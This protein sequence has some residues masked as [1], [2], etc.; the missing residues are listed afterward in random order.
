MVIICPICNK[1]FKTYPSNIK[2]GKG[3]FCSYSCRSINFSGKNNPNFGKDFSGINNPFYGK[4]HSIKTRKEY[5]RNRIGHWLGNKNPR[6]NNGRTITNGYIS[7]FQ[8]NHP[9]SNK[10]YVYEHRFV[11]EKI[12]GRYLKPKEHVHHINKNKTDNRFQNLMAFISNSAHRRFEI[13]KKIIP[14]E[15]IFNGSH[16]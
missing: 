11:V 12:I 6:W 13:S 10:H 8:K 15:I 9:Y 16:I 5:S 7:I 2:R 14:K 1:E 4:K 3:K